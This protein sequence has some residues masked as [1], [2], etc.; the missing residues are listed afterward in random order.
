MPVK[1]PL[2]IFLRRRLWLLLLLGSACLDPFNVPFNNAPDGPIVIDAFLNGT[3]GTATVRLSYP[4]GITS[5]DPTVVIR[6]ASVAVVSPTARFELVE[7]SPGTYSAS[8]IPTTPGTVFTLNV[9][10]SDGRKFVSDPTPMRATPE[11]DS[12][13]FAV[14]FDKESFEVSVNTHDPS[15]SAQYFSWDYEETYEYTAAYFSG[16]IYD[17]VNPKPRRDE[18]L[19][20][21][22]W[23]T[24][25]ST[26]IGIVTTKDLSGSIVNKFRINTIPA[27]SIKLSIRYSIFVKQRVIGPEEYAYLGLLK[28]T[29]EKLGGLFDPQPSTIVGNLHEV[30]QPNSVV[31]G[32]FSACQ[33]SEKRV[34]IRHEELPLSLQIPQPKVCEQ[35][36]TCLL[37]GDRG[38][39]CTPL[40]IVGYNH[41]LLFAVYGPD[42]TPST[43][44][45][46]LKE[47]ADCRLQGG[48]PKRPAFW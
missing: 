42:G 12:I 14:G 1:Q 40:E 28:K 26:S 13:T 22:C 34:F 8:G 18:D 25:P 30:G 10:T 9:Q 20:Y 4:Q 39:D 17:K 46:T 27:G 23:R 24:I 43:F 21:R 33:V 3:T 5:K 41:E 7:N 15:D 11:L 31:L 37:P 2:V 29:T 16:F 38:F 32:Y 35:K 48:I 47:C 45:Y 19:I 36:F 6:G 44:A